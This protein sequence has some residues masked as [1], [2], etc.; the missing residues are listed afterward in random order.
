M[1]VF[2]LVDRVAPGRNL[3]VCGQ[4]W[5]FLA[6]TV[7][8]YCFSI[9]VIFNT[10]CAYNVILLVSLVLFLRLFQALLTL[11]LDMTDDDDNIVMDSPREDFSSLDTTSVLKP[12][13]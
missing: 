8:S 7:I 3:L 2:T 4:H 13:H 5:L 10:Q 9:T 12:V 1:V 6:I 11:T